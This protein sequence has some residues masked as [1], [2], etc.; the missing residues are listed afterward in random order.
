MQKIGLIQTIL[1]P[2]P[3]RYLRF[4]ILLPGFLVLL[5]ADILLGSVHIPLRDALSV[6]TGGESEVK[7]W[8]YIIHNIRIPKALTATLAG[9]ALAVSGL[10]MQTL[11]RNPLASPS[12]L[13]ISAGAAL[14]TGF[15]IFAGGSAGSIVNLHRLGIG[16]SWLLALSASLGAALVFSVLLVISRFVRDHVVLL[17]VGLLLGTLTLSLTTIWQYYSK[18]EQ[19]QAF[20]SWTFGSLGGVS[21]HQLTVLASV[22]VAGIL[23]S[24]SLSKT[25]NAL[26]LG[27][28]NAAT[29]GISIL[30]ARTFILINTCILTGTVTAFCGPI[31]FIGIAV[32]HLT[33]S[34]LNTSNHLI[35][36]PAC[37]LTGA[38]LLLACDIIAQLPGSGF[39]LPIN[40]AT[41]LVGAPVVIWII[42]KMNNLRNSF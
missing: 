3:S 25:L 5:V 2:T 13:G 31:G 17:I 29:L 7:A 37:C 14:G 39:V 34:L 23:A 40:V 4:S 41:S 16:T 15:L 20:I 26:L 33:R 8:S 10:Q 32:P 35:L 30:R 19:L 18:P 27:E 28:H 24:F 21:G 12:E 22:S 36:L 6:L 38:M 9:A 42:L 1:Y 11:F